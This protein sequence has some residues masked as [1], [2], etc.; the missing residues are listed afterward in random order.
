MASRT[1]E[2]SERGV[3]DAADKPLMPEAEASP[4]KPKEAVF[5]LAS[6]TVPD[7]FPRTFLIRSGRSPETSS[8]TAAVPRR[9]FTGFLFGPFLTERL[10]GD[11]SKV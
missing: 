8:L 3:C 11:E 9:N 10:L 1:G 7:A 4:G 5:W 6:Q 2:K